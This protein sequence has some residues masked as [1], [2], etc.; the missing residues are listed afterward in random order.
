M[1][2]RSRTSTGVRAEFL[3]QPYIS[4]YACLK[5]ETPVN[6]Q[7]TRSVLS[8][9]SECPC[10]KKSEREEVLR[11]GIARDEWPPQE[12]INRIRTAL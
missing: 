12:T 7:I 9:L 4:A 5:G 8:D 1:M 3:P 6:F 11:D 10:T 2:L